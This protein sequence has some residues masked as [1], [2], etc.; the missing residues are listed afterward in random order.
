MQEKNSE[1]TTHN[2]KEPKTH[3]NPPPPPLRGWGGNSR[4]GHRIASGPGKPSR[5]SSTGIDQTA[6]VPRRQGYPI[7]G[8]SKTLPTS[9]QQYAT[10]GFQWPS[11]GPRTADNKS[12]SQPPE[13]AFSESPDWEFFLLGCPRDPRLLV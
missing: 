8:S 11:N 9:Q 4:P 10:D 5:T 2:F 12:S 3:V 1:N 6:I 7:E 13:A